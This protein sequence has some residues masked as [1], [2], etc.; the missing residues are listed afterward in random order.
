MCKCISISLDL[1]LYGM[2]SGRVSCLHEK[3]FISLEN[4]TNSFVIDLLF[5][6][7]SYMRS[8]ILNLFFI[9]GS[10]KTLPNFFH[11]YQASN[12]QNKKNIISNDRR[13]TKI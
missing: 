11:K 1:A 8:T 5:H 10:N 7:F 13:S 12:L 2:H 6:L 3:S 4:I 9:S